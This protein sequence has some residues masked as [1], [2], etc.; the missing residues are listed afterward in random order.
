MV[1]YILVLAQSQSFGSI[2]NRNT[3][4]FR[5]GNVNEALFFVISLL[6]AFVILGGASGS[7]EFASMGILFG[8]L[9]IVSLIT[10]VLVVLNC[11]FRWNIF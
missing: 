9:S 5:I 2:C 8:L 4:V 1:N 3:F 11:S 7:E 10:A 6:F